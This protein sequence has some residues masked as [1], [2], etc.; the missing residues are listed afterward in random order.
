MCKDIVAT[1]K[2]ARSSEVRGPNV[3][4][5][6]NALASQLTTAVWNEGPCNQIVVKQAVLFTS[7]ATASNLFP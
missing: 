3:S 5:L 2:Q 1:N 6:A 7:K 4:L